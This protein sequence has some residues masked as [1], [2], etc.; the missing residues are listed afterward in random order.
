MFYESIGAASKK[1]LLESIPKFQEERVFYFRH[2]K[3]NKISFAIA[4]GKTQEMLMNGSAWEILRLC[5]G[6]RTVEE[7]KDIYSDRYISINKSADYLKDVA[8]TLMV[9]DKLWALSWGKDGSPF[10]VNETVKLNEELE[11]EWVNENNIRDIA[12]AYE[13]FPELDGYTYHNCPADRNKGLSDYQKETVLRS[14]LFYYKEDFFLIKD[15]QKK[16]QGV[17]SVCNN[18]PETD[19]VEITTIIVPKEIAKISLEGIAS[20]LR[21]YYPFHISK[22]RIKTIKSDL[23]DLGEQNLLECGYKNTALLENEYGVGNDLCIYDLFL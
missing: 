4:N 18:Y 2:E 14:K 5:D 9:F 3:A 15:M 12:A 10:M 23:E 16:M 7:I 21:E 1:K 11:L 20:I 17:I 8:I 13:Q 22:I 6:K 19:I